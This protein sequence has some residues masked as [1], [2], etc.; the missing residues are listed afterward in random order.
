MFSN[1]FQQPHSMTLPSPS[2]RSQLDLPQMTREGISPEMVG[3]KGVHRPQL[4]EIFMHINDNL[5]N[6]VARTVMFSH[7]E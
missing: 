1:R 7:F 6:S 4:Q 2:L 5:L 3:T